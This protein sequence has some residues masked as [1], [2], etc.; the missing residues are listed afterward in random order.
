MKKALALLLAML[1]LATAFVACGKAPSEAPAPSSVPAE[2]TL[3]SDETNE[4]VLCTSSGDYITFLTE[5]VVPKFNEL[6][7]NVKVTLVPDEK[8]EE[9]IAAGD[10]PNVYTGAFAARGMRYANAG[11]IVPL[12]DFE[13]YDDLA[14]RIDEQHLVQFSDYNF[15]IPWN[16]TTTM[17]IYNKDLFRQAG[18][19]PEQP[20][21]TYAEFLEYAA[22]IDALGNDVSGT[23]FWNMA[24]G[25]GGWYWDMIAP[26]YYNF[27]QGQYQLMNSMGTDVV[28]DKEE[29]HMKDLFNF[30]KEAGKY[31]PATMDDNNSFF[32]RNVGMWLQFGYGWKANLAS[33]HGSPM[34][35]GEDVGVAPIPVLNEGDTPFSTLGGNGLVI[36]KNDDVRKQELSWEL[37][38][39]MMDEDLN[40][41]ACK[42][43]GQ[44]PSLTALQDNEFFKGPQ[45]LPFVEQS[46]NATPSEPYAEADAIAALVLQAI[47]SSVIDGSVSVDDAIASAATQAR[48][49]LK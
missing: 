44:L 16:L 8:I 45:E 20:P 38:K 28:F 23:I 4:I 29:A 15:Y 7:P 31:A 40:L 10:L 18:L 49:M 22:K 17:M 34:V 43:L 47:Q 21:K 2:P 12:N 33:A 39:V 30:L 41:E 27:N 11:L 24:L 32:N 9:K 19:D 42:R 25:W 35:V 36:F 5:N 46:K 13:G 1:V 3:G 14:A 26:M 6:Y 48:D 37:I